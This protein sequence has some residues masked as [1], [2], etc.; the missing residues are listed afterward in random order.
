MSY[1][2][3]EKSLIAQIV[4]GD[5]DAENRMFLHF[6]ERIEFLVRVRLRNQVSPDDQQDILSEA[7]QAILLSLRKGGF[8]PAKEKPLEA[9]IAGIVSNVVAMYFRNLTRAKQTEDIDKHHRIESFSN[10]LSE[11]LNHEKKEKIK[12]ALSSLDEKYKEVLLLRI[13]EEQS[14]DEISENIGIEKRR[15]SERINYALKLLLKE[16][17]KQNYF[18]YHDS[19]DK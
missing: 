2:F 5:S 1:I 4:A 14:I 10:P 15:V 18:Q 9:Y 12:S 19:F 13:Y 16:L 17:K 6:K 7:K 8:D 3:D 11:I